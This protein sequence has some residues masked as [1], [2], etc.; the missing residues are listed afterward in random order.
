MRYIVSIAL[1]ALLT[2]CAPLFE[3]IVP[4]TADMVS[5]V[6]AG[7]VLIIN[8]LPEDPIMK[9]LNPDYSA[10]VATGTGFFIDEN[11]IITNNHVI[12]GGGKISIVSPDSPKEYEAE[13]LKTD[14]IADI[15][16]VT[17]KDWKKYKEE[18]K[19]VMLPLGDSETLKQ[20]EKIIA[21]GHPW[22]LTWSVSEG[23]LS[24]QNRRIGPTPKFLFQIDAYV[25]PGNSGGPVFNSYGEV[26][27]VNEIMKVGST[28]NGTGIPDAVGTYGLCIPSNLVK[29]V[30]Y[31]MKTL[32]EVRW[33]SLKS[34]ISLT[35]DRG[36][37][38]FGVIEPGGPA[39]KAGFKVNDKILAVITN[40]T[41]PEGR[42]TVTPDDVISQIA[43]MKGDEENV[44]ILIERNGEKMVIEAKT[45][46]RLSKEFTPEDAK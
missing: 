22:G 13:V 39:D 31:D 19:P 40:A 7:T 10:P 1:L 3:R 5:S 14:V 42:K 4:P 25:Y 33:R 12:D 35:D 41:G 18:Q 30:V 11:T 23:I 44:K 24:A 2:G 21:I 17:L 29:K 16:I 15:A 9:A 36:S 20:G 8:E 28:D 27:C 38:I 34:T 37:V 32:G 26:V 6:K 46:F 43:L 45:G